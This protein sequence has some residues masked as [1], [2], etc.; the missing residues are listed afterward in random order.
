MID[1]EVSTLEQKITP[2]QL[3]VFSPGEKIQLR[4]GDQQT[5][6][7]MI[8]GPPLSQPRTIFWNFVS[9]NQE[10]IEAA[11]KSWKSG[12]FRLPEGETEF[13]PLPES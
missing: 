8:G 6:M 4:A 10:L 5:R 7:M 2:D 9:T 11:K 12:E 13:I 1:G 3:A